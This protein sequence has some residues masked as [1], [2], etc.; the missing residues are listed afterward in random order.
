MDELL[1]KLDR[2]GFIDPVAAA[3]E[4]LNLPIMTDK[5]DQKNRDWHEFEQNDPSER[6]IAAVFRE[7]AD[8]DDPDAVLKSHGRLYLTIAKG[9]MRRR[10][11]PNLVKKNSS[12]L[13]VSPNGSPAP[14]ADEQSRL[15]K[16][17]DELAHYFDLIA[18]RPG[19]PQKEELDAALIELAEIFAR[20]TN[21][22]G[23][24]FA[25]PF[26]EDSR[27]IKFAELALR[28][29]KFRFEEGTRAALSSRWRMLCK[30]RERRLS[31]KA[32][33]QQ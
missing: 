3:D 27:F 33:N 8:A 18:P 28:Q 32:N 15:R 1:S 22:S 9:R 7:A 13:S 23:P 31:V 2:L 6:E 10:V 17:C 11:T 14:D 4:I 19:R 30:P 21:N 26:A 5:A 24:L 29:A 12:P 16:A 20:H 25:L